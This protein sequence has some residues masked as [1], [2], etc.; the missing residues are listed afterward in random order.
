MKETAEIIDPGFAVADG[1]RLSLATEGEDL[2]LSFL[3]W[4]ARNVTAIFVNAISYRWDRLDWA[5]LEEERYDA[6]HIIHNSDW[7]QQ[8]VDQRSIENNERYNHYR[9]NFNAAGTLQVIAREIKV[10]TDPSS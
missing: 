9:L 10:I 5:Y 3:D 8:H 2:K 6:S 1:E 7:L 4:N